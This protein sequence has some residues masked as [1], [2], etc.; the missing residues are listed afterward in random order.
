MLKEGDLSFRV[1]E[2]SERTDWYSPA[3]NVR[4]ALS[5]LV[6]VLN[7]NLNSLCVIRDTNTSNNV[8]FLV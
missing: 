6:F 2:Y 3:V 5:M 7:P 8:L 4:L 1:A